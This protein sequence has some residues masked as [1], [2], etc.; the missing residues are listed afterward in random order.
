MAAS[1][2]MTTMAVPLEGSEVNL[3]NPPWIGYQLVSTAGVCVVLSSTLL[4]LRLFT[5]EIILRSLGWDDL[6]ITLAWASPRQLG[7]I[8]PTT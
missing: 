8:G 3:I 7:G 1:T 4:G 2:V 6:L 5:R